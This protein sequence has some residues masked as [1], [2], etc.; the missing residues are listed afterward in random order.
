M[1]HPNLILASARVGD[2]TMN[3]LPSGVTVHNSDGSIVERFNCSAQA[4]TV[5]F[6]R[7]RDKAKMYRPAIKLGN[8][9]QDA[10]TVRVLGWDDVPDMDAE[11][12][13]RWALSVA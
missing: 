12:V 5:I 10:W 13:E 11:S 4:A 9:S 7:I 2:K 6:D 1:Q 8:G 3:L